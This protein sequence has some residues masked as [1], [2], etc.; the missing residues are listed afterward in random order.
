MT[1]PPQMNGNAPILPNGQTAE[2]PA[3]VTQALLKAVRQAAEKALTAQGQDCKDFLTA[4]LQG[5]QAIIVLDPSL[6]QGGTP[7]QHDIAMKAL[8]GETQKAVAVIQGEAAAKVADVN[9]QHAFRQAKETAAAPTPRKKLTVARD[10]S[11]RM[12]GISE[13]G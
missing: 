6:S 1:A 2:D 10:G 5:A 7:L 3:M 9:G 4:A 8:E 13:E 12:T 11:G